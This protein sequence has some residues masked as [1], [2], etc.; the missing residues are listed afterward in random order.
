VAPAAEASPAELKK[1]V[2]PM[3]LQKLRDRLSEVEQRVAE[4][5]SEIAQTE[6]ALADFKSVEETL[7]LSDQAAARRKQLE[8]AVAEW[9]AVS[10][11]LETNS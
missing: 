11:E 5:E 6:T 9:E 3:K 1:R 10:A 8:G 7:R 2:N 4:L